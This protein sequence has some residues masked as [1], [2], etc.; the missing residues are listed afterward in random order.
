[1]PRGARLH[2]F[3]DDTILSKQLRAEQLTSRSG[4]GSSSQGST[5]NAPSGAMGIGLSR[6]RD[7]KGRNRQGTRHV[8][9][10]VWGSRASIQHTCSFS[11]L[12]ACLLIIANS[13]PVAR[14][15]SRL[16]SRFLNNSFVTTPFMRTEVIIIAASCLHVYYSHQRDSH[17]HTD[18]QPALSHTGG[19]AHFLTQNLTSTPRSQLGLMHVQ[20]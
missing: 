1:M 7:I 3:I 14:V 18:A 5:D 11:F 4:H 8:S 9:L 20:T 19:D 12:D 17:H 16:M 2:S 15:L 10:F 6:L 13:Y